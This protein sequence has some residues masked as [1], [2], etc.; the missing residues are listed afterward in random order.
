MAMILEALHSK[1]FNDNRA[2]NLS[3]CAPEISL[4]V[5]KIIIALA[6]ANKAAMRGVQ[7]EI[8]QICNYG[9]NQTNGKGF[10]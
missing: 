5:G 9:C 7:L 2:H 10:L 6:I 1:T 4:F 8:I 3:G